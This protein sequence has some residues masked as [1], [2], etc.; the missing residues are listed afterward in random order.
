MS[1][2]GIFARIVA[3]I[4]AAMIL[5]RKWG[6]ETDPPAV[7]GSPMIPEAK[8]QGIPTLKMP[9]A[10]GWVGD[11]TPTAAP[12]LKVNAFARDLKHPRWVY[13]LPNNDV[14][15]AEALGLPWEKA[16]TPFEYAMFST[17]KRAKAVGESANRISIFRDLDGDGVGEVH[18]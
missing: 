16:K 4:G 2:S 14:L 9:T 6:K 11:H 18:D 17:M 5:M 3:W 8:A 1:I 7:G 13:V 10:K 12:G 15:V